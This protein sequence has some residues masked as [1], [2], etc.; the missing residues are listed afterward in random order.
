VRRSRTSPPI[1]TDYTA[2]LEAFNAAGDRDGALEY[3]QVAAVG[4]PQEMVDGMKGTA[5]WRHVAEVA[6]TIVYD[7]YCL[8]GDDQSLP[9]AL[10]EGLAQP[11]LALASTGSPPF[12]V[13]PARQVGAL[14]P[15]GT[16]ELVEGEFHTAPDDVLAARIAAFASPAG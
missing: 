4:L 2:R 6:P 14:A 7:G 13:E 1:P 12:L 15:H 10:L 11:V 3:F 5:M 9:V 8:G 16:F